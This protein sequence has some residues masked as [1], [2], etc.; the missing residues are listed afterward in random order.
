[1][2]LCRSHP[3]NDGSSWAVHGCR[4][5]QPLVSLL[6]GLLRGGRRM[7]AQGERLAL[8]AGLELPPEFLHLMQR[9]WAEAPA[10]R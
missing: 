1:M 3:C 5:A 4:S 10:S 6:G 7:G 9:C 8:P 2:A